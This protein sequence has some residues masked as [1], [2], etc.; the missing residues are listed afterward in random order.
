MRNAK[1]KTPTKDIATENQELMKELQELQAS[2]EV[3]ENLSQTLEKENQKLKMLQNFNSV[4]TKTQASK[5]SAI[6]TQILN[7]LIKVKST[8]EEEVEEISKLRKDKADLN[9]K[10]SVIDQELGQIKPSTGE[11]V[12]RGIRD[13]SFGGY[14]LK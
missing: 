7:E 5:D 13:K 11:I 10:I 2:I 14:S 12:R 6:I 9:N 3:K 4:F 8:I 1:E